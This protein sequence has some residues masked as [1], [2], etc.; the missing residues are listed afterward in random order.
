MSSTN[1]ENITH[2]SFKD[3]WENFYSSAGAPAEPSLFAQYV[4]REYL[5][6]NSSVVELGCGNGR[7]S[8]YFASKGMRVMA[9]D[10]CKHQIRLLNQTHEGS[11]VNFVAKDFTVMEP[12]NDHNA[13]YSR[14]TLH[15]VSEKSE[16]RVISWS[17][18]QLK[19]GNPFLIEARGLNNEL[20][21]VGKQVEGE[22]DAFVHDNHYR[23]FI[24]LPQIT[25]KLERVGFSI[26]QAEEA[27]GFSPYNG[28]DETFIR[29]AA[30][31]I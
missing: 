23:R 15:S 10:Q 5:Q 20:F 8:I 29:V 18:A 24:H 17:A 22:R 14:F 1:N 4:A 31:K 30:I 13:V 21:G 28:T 26:V 11:S 25:K 12:T 3:Y 7:D 9:V 6:G 2:R 27:S 19:T 16:D